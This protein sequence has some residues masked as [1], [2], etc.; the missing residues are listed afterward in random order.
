M[1]GDWSKPNLKVLT[2]YAVP[3]MVYCGNSTKDNAH[4][5]IY[6]GE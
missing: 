1:A 5:H 6:N 3:F 4:V 2:Q